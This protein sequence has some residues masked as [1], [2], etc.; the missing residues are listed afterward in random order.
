MNL[1]HAETNARL[2]TLAARIGFD[3]DLDKAKKEIFRHL[4]NILWLSKEQ[5]YDLY[6]IIG[7]KNSRLEIFMGLPNFK[8]P[9]HVKRVLEKELLM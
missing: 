8:K 6:N 7:K 4:N 5:Q 9:G 1:L 3:M 2:D